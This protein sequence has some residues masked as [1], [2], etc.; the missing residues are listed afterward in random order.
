M[1]QFRRHAPMA[2]LEGRWMRRT[3]FGLAAT[4]ALCTSMSALVAQPARGG[5]LAYGERGPFNNFNPFA[6]LARNAATDRVLSMIY[7]PLFRFNFNLQKWENVLGTEVRKTAPRTGKSAFVVTLRDATWHDGTPFRAADVVFTYEYARKV[8]TTK[9]ERDFLIDLFAEIRV[10]EKPSE[11]IVE[12]KREVEDARVYLREFIIPAARFDPRTFEPTARDKDLDRAPMG[13]GPY[14]VVGFNGAP[15]LSRNDKYHSVVGSLE[16]IE[17]RLFTDGESMVQTLLASRNDGIGLIVELPPEE[18]QR[19][20]SR[21]GFTIEDVPSYNVLAVEMRQRPNSILNNEKVRRAITMAINREQ[22]LKTWFIKGELLASPVMK[23]APAFDP[24]VKPI[25]Y[26][27]EQARRII[28]EAGAAGKELRFIYPTDVG[29]DSHVKDVV[30]SIAEALKAVGITVKEDPKTI[31][32][33]E[34]I[35]L[36]TLDFDLAWGHWEF[37]QAYDVTPLFRSKSGQ[38]MANLNNMGFSDPE[39]DRLA[40][41]YEKTGDDSNRQALMKSMQR[42]LNEKAPAIFLVSEVKSYAYNVKYRIPSGA[43]D[44]FYFFTYVNRWRLGKP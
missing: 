35:R 32:E 19:V 29:T 37:N 13:T 34:N 8:G 9:S 3:S 27:Q 36:S 7:E 17:P 24:T 16:T 2:Y 26:D 18:I 23:Q 42:L 4:V 10:G 38:G 39:F 28:R 14:R 31:A 12:F 15:L 1:L 20:E 11:V 40:S 22:L 41:D 44:P 25:P 33:F 43:V 21:G 6:S 5:A 30:R